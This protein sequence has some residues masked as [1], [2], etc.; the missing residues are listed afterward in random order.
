MRIRRWWGCFT[1]SLVLIGVVT[2]S[3]TIH[4]QSDVWSND[5]LWAVLGFHEMDVEYVVQFPIKRVGYWS[6][7]FAS[8][9]LSQFRD[10]RNMDG[11]KLKH[12]IEFEGVRYALSA[13][14]GE[15]VPEDFDI[16][17]LLAEF[18]ELADI[19]E[20]LQVRPVY[21][22]SLRT[23]LVAIIL[24]TEQPNGI[25]RVSLDEQHQIMWVQAVLG[26]DL[27]LA[28]HFFEGF[29]VK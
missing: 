13:Y 29:E 2:A 5:V 10:S 8:G 1:L 12:E 23:N 26:D 7:W 24:Q 21:T 15:N 22:D 6:S 16:Y 3:S 27:S 17:M 14:A 28:E 9:D 20:D 4:R 19:N 18:E 11:T 25:Q